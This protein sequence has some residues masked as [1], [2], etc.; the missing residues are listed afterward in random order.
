MRT[1]TAIRSFTRA[2]IGVIKM[3]TNPPDEIVNCGMQVINLDDKYIYEFK[4]D[5][6]E[7]VKIRPAERADYTEIPQLF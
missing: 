3:L 5:K 7:W 6:I 1:A 2:D 4:E